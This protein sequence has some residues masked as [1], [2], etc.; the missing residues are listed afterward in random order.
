M[1]KFFDFLFYF[2]KSR[3]IFCFMDALKYPM[4]SVCKGTLT[5]V[6]P[7]FIGDNPGMNPFFV[8]RSRHEYQGGFF[9]NTES[10]KKWIIG[11][12]RPRIRDIP[13]R[14]LESIFDGDYNRLDTL[15]LAACAAD[16]SENLG[17][18]NVNV[19][20]AIDFWQTKIAEGARYW[21]QKLKNPELNAED[22]RNDVIRWHAE[23]LKKFE[24]KIEDFNRK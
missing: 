24:K 8:H 23:Y 22:I 10:Y 12:L 17:E 4:A 6:M 14:E 20:L 16:L 5:K 2:L 19:D 11:N 1:S 7:L 3:F 18:N 9:D 13:F 21:H 15:I